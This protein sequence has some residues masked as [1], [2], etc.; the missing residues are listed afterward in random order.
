VL[1]LIAISLGALMGFAGISVDV[2]Y[3]EY[4]QQAQQSATDAAAIGGAQQ[5]AHNNCAN[6]SGAVTAALADASTNGFTN[7]SNNVAISATSPPASG[8]FSGNACAVSVQITTSNVAT[9]FSRLF[10]YPN[11]MAESTQAVGTVSAANNGACIYLLSMNTWSSFN[12]PVNIQAPHCAI[13]INFNADWDGG[14]VSSPFIGYAGSNAPN[15]GGTTFPLASPVPMLPV[16]DPCPQIPGCAY[17]AANPPPQSN[18]T[19][20]NAPSGG[21]TINPGCYTYI[22]GGGGTITMNPG[23][24]VITQ[25][26]NTNNTNFT[27]SGVTIYIPSGGNPPNFDNAT[28]NL[29]PPSTGN[30]QGVLYYQVPS[31]TSNPNFNGPK[32]NM[33]GLIYCP[34]AQINYDGNTGNYLVIVAGSANFN[35]NTAEEFASPPPGGSYI[36]Q[37]VLGQ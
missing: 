21:T 9:Y 2:G 27:G 19:G 32:V 11:G 20:L 28:V 17:L 36:K 30:T 24:Y 22:N 5:L 6:P 15:Y 33:Q 25:N 3:L 34:G 12:S 31:N 8:P 35:G 26:I 7:G 1:P 18:C 16:A 37:A 29:S 13:D 14:T 4:R 10:G 23:T